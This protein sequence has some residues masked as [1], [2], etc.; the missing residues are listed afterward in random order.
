MSARAVLAKIGPL[1]GLVAVFLFFFIAVW[2]HTGRNFFATRDNLETIALQSA[3]VG[4]AALGMTIVII[5]GGIDLSMGSAVA[6]TSV[7]VAALLK[8]R[9]W[10]AFPSAL[11]AIGAG[12]LCGVLNGALVTGLKVVPFIITLGTS[13]MLRGVA[14]EIAD[15]ATITPSASSLDFLLDQS[16]VLPSG[17][18]ML[19][20]LGAVVSA[21]L[22]YT[23]F[24]RH[25]VA[26]GSNEQAARLCGVPIARTKIL[27]YALG[28]LFAGLAGLLQYSRLTIGDPTSAP[29]LEL[30]VI[31]AVVIG[32]A[33]L[34]GGEG[35]VAGSLVGALLMTMIRNG[36]SQMGWPNNRTEIVAGVIII[37]A[38]AVDRLRHRRGL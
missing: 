18:W 34:A 27:V 26:I 9:G 11:G 31:A 29:G 25:V 23:R 33:S 1:L 12:A 32:G 22:G 30:D 10:P 21:V 16:G 2:S 35:S 14:K 6:L 5:S 36:C 3:I 20:V 24:G 4:M 19:A 15:N 17:V 7:V 28:G 13:L 37:V 38:V 8:F